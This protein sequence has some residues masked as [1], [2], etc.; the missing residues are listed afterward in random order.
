M[1]HWINVE[2]RMMT[3]N[4]NMTKL[5]NEQASKLTCV[6]ERCIEID[7][8]IMNTLDHVVKTCDICSGINS[9]VEKEHDHISE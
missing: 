3:Q 2:L 4:E 6:E 9:H 7:E 8:N 1:N 5:V